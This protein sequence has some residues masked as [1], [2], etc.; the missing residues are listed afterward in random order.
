MLQRRRIFQ[1]KSPI[2]RLRGTFKNCQG[3]TVVVLQGAL[4]P[5]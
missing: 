5:E 3:L 1:W 2:K 4:N